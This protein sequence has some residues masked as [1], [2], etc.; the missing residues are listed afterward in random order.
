[1]E[2]LLLKYLV[3]SNYLNIDSQD[4]K[5][6]LLAHPDYPSL[7][8]ITDTLDYFEIENIAALI[9]KEYL[10]QLPKNFLTLLE[11]EKEKRLV[12][13]S[14]NNSN[15]E[16]TYID[17]KNT[18]KKISYTNFL[19][20]WDPTIVAIEPL[21]ESKK[22]TSKISTSFLVLS[23]TLI[24]I[25][26][27]SFSNFSII[28][29]LYYFSA[30]G[31]GYISFLIAKEELGFNSAAVAKF[32]NQF[33]NSSCADVIKSDGS[34]IFNT[35]ALSDIAVTYALSSILFLL[36]YGFTNSFSF[37]LGAL[38][39]PIIIYAVFYQWQV[40]KSWCLLCLGISGLMIVSF[41][42]TLLN[43]KGFS[44]PTTELLYFGFIFSVI[45]FSWSKIKSVLKSNNQLKS[46]QIDFLKFKRNYNLFAMLLNSQT[47]IKE[48]NLYETANIIHFGN[49][50]ASLKIIA[51]TNP[52]CGFCK[53]SFEMYSKL[54]AKYSNQIQV[55]F[56][57]NVHYENVNHQGTQISH[58]LIEKFYTKSNEDCFEAFKQW[59]E[60]RDI[61]SWQKK[62]GISTNTDFIDSLGFQNNWCKLNEINYTPAT[63]INGKIFP[64]EYDIS[65]LSFFIDELIT[66]KESAISE[67]ESAVNLIK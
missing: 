57:F 53:K 38:S 27:F 67:D 43:F 11:I 37:L 40:L 64:K 41:T 36:F 63:F 29:L 19:E 49:P 35:I 47:P 14:K 12:L 58:R 66:E 61:S 42:L 48:N 24:S 45:G 32:C 34:K 2:K 54:L 65:D 39:L 55:T 30:L 8:S 25:A 18:K 20:Q 17:D 31:I 16:V 26:V 50:K 59:F 51:V 22:Q 1:M 5:L 21:K 9:P 4:L 60:D 7:K 52:L 10:D 6:Q 28:P 46:T 23:L 56:I 33:S 44:F 3:E 15:T 13:I 62:F